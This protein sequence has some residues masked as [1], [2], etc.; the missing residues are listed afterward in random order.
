MDFLEQYSGKVRVEV[1]FISEAAR[2]VSLTQSRDQRKT[3]E[4][5]NTDLETLQKNSSGF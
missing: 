1:G 5:E 4:E 3:E 2:S